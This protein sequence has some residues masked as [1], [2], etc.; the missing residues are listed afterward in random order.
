MR[1][2]LLDLCVCSVT[3]TVIGLIYYSAVLILGER[4]QAKW[5]YYTWMVIIA[6]YLFPWKPDFGL[7]VSRQIYMPA[8]SMPKETVEA[9]QILLAGSYFNL[10]SLAQVLAIIWFLTAFGL[11]VGLLIRHCG[12]MERIRRLSIK[13]DSEQVLAITEKYRHRFG[14]RRPVEVRTVDG[15]SSPM[16]VGF[17]RP[18][19]LIPCEEFPN[20]ELELILKH[21]LVHYKRKDLWLKTLAEAAAVLHWFNPAVYLIKR[22]FERDMEISCDEEAVKDLCWEERKLYCTA[23]IRVVRRQASSAT[24]FST[25]FRS[26]S[27]WMKKRMEEILSQKRQS[28]YGFL[29]A[30][31]L[32]AVMFGSVSLRFQLDIGERNY[33]DGMWQATTAVAGTV[34]G[35][36]DPAETAAVNPYR[37]TAF[38]VE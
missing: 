13:S 26:G 27:H 6:G 36:E 33:G 5:R 32:C 14:I 4:Y 28:P 30:A 10:P 23:I 37:V 3:M 17:L 8:G 24:A 7:F 31:V 25:G 34:A 18:L 19:V 16:L 22:A 11:G 12:F 35:A 29:A 2:L 9:G 21:E 15:I 1:Q 20:M 38:T